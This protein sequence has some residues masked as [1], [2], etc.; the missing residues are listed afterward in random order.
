[1]KLK[2]N[3]VGE[4]FTFYEQKLLFFSSIFKLELKKNIFGLTA[5]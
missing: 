1:M 5:F 4:K 3:P 2:K